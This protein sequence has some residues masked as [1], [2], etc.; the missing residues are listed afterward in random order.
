MSHQVS[1]AGA[2]VGRG[3]KLWQDGLWTNRGYEN[4]GKR[5][6][7]HSLVDEDPGDILVA[8]AV[9]A[10][11]ILVD[12]PVLEHGAVPVIKE[13]LTCDKHRLQM[14][15]LCVCPE[16]VLANFLKGKTA[17]AHRMAD[18][19]RSRTGRCSCLQ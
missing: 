4:L 6:R 13:V 2:G 11:D 12:Q 3:T 9:F 16:P 14:S 1:N 19:R 17:D 15:L 8:N 5:G 10:E 18:H 7:F